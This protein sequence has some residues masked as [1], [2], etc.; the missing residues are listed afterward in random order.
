[1]QINTEIAGLILVIGVFTGLGT[2]LVITS[3]NPNRNSLTGA[4]FKVWTFFPRAGSMSD[5]R[6][7]L[8]NG[9]GLMVAAVFF[10]ILALIR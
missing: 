3:R 8:I 6:W 9:V 1:M 4:I 7:V 5:A 2:L 10:L